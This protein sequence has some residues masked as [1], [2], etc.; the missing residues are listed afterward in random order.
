MFLALLYAT[1]PIKDN[2]LATQMDGRIDGQTSLGTSNGHMR[3]D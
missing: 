3:V 2:G 1:I